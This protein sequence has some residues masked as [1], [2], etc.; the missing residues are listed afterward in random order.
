M[1]KEMKKN[2]YILDTNVLRILASEFV[3][4]H[5]S[6]KLK[7][8]ELIKQFLN[9]RP[10]QILIPDLIWTEFAAI[11]FQKGV[12]VENYEKYDLWYN[13][14]MICMQQIKSKLV[15]W[16]A[17]EILTTEVV[18]SKKIDYYQFSKKI[19]AIKYQVELIEAEYKRMKDKLENQEKLKTKLENSNNNE[20]KSKIQQV[21]HDISRTKN[22]F[23]KGTKFL[24]G[25]DPMILAMSAYY[26]TKAIDADPNGKVY[27]I[28][29]DV[30]FKKAANH[31]QKRQKE[32]GLQLQ[33]NTEWKLE[34]LSLHDAA[35]IAQRAVG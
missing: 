18:S 28:S 2:Y 6:R 9:K 10:G 20:D 25:M 26:A 32:Y 24:D 23:N 3:D 22:D 27:I 4:E 13:N 35:K 21:K 30:A 1:K 15:K 11:F 29:D 19:A 8:V 7:K 34:V 12:S 5:D 33:E 31:V 14:R 17:K 16:D